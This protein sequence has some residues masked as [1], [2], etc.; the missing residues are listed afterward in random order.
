[1]LAEEDLPDP[2]RRPIVEHMVMVHQMVRTQSEE[3][4]QQLKRYN[5]VTPKNYLDFI[6]N[7]RSVLKEERRKIDGSIQRLDG[8]L[9]KL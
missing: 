5:Y 8:G 9:S 1:F 6:S 4:L 2:S 3:F 7:Y